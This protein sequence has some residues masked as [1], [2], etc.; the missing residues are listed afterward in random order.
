[1]DEHEDLL[2]TVGPVPSF[3][4]VPAST[5]GMVDLDRIVGNIPV[6]L[7]F[8][9]DPAEAAGREL[10]R[11]L[12]QH[13]VDF[14]RDRIQ[15]LAV[16]PLDGTRVEALDG[17][18]EGNARI[19]ADPDRR[20]ADRL[21]VAY[22]PGRPVTAL[23]GADGNLVAVWSDQADGTFAEAVLARISQLPA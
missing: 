23:I 15:V 8:L 19:L 9:E 10:L 21:G 17:A 16:A 4:E 5:G 18:T 13:L 11:S 7:V 12:G 1:M 2:P 20:L 6:V 3:G 22:W 14:G